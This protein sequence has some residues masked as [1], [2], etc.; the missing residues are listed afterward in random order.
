[1][2]KWKIYV[3]GGA[4]ILLAVLILLASIFG[5]IIMRK[6]DMSNLL[7]K[8]QAADLISI[9]DPGYETGDVL[10]NK[11]KEILLNEAELQEI[12][13]LLQAVADGG[14]SYKQEKAFFGDSSGLR[15]RARLGEEE[16]VYLWFSEQELYY[17]SNETAV[18]FTANHAEAYAALYQKMRD[19]LSTK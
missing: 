13:S 18:C 14:Y 6:S 4:L 16:T 17:M 7:A 19:W 9:Y 1:M 3:F 5:P 15:L 8:V 10:G 11:G 12:K 2:K